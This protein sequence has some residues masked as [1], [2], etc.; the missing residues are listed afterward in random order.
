[1]DEKHLCEAGMEIYFMETEPKYT[2]HFGKSR[3]QQDEVCDGQHGKKIEHRFVENSL[4]FDDKK[5]E[6]VSHEGNNI[7]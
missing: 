3:S 5:D 1:M 6:Y 7:H 4:S 2:Q